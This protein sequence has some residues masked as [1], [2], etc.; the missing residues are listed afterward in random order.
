MIQRVEFLDIEV[1]DICVSSDDE[2][3]YMLRSGIFTN[4]G[5]R[6]HWFKTTNTEFHHWS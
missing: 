6:F 2:V 4:S 1:G 3:Q 5:S